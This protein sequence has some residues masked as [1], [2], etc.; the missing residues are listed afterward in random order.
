LHSRDTFGQR[1]QP[2]AR[3]VLN[4]IRGGDIVLLHD[5]HATAGRHRSNAANALPLI[6][7]GLQAQNL[8]AV[9]VSQLLADS[10]P[11]AVGG[12]MDVPRRG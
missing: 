4:R 7:C 2:I 1:W 6:L 12:H 11:A 5:G 9:T 8:Q 3:R 10:P